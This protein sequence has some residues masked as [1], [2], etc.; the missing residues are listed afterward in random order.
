MYVETQQHLKKFMTAI[1]RGIGVFDG[2]IELE[3]QGR[4]KS[5]L[6]EIQAELDDIFFS[7]PFDSEYVSG[8]GWVRVAKVDDSYD[9]FVD[10]K[11]HL[12]KAFAWAQKLG[13]DHALY[14][15]CQ[16][17]YKLTLSELLVVS[18]IKGGPQ[19]AWDHFLHILLRL[20]RHLKKAKDMLNDFR[21][22][23]A[24]VRFVF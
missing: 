17:Y 21:K 12:D 3:H 13:T 9:S 24:R 8:N 19:K 11:R 16:K 7:Q 5:E 22:K 10:A 4:K 2:A 18:S 23:A 14:A 15:T 6:T 20:A 1:N